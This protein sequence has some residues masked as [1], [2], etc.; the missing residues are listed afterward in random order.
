MWDL[1][2]GNFKEPTY[3]IYDHEEEILSACMHPTDPN[4]MASV[5]SEGCVIV[6]DLRVPM[7]PIAEI[8]HGTTEPA[9]AACLAFNRYS[10]DEIFVSINNTINLY[11]VDGNHVQTH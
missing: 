3:T 4:L 11:K 6:R 1:Q 8:R 2:S 5:D 7:D 10:P 9:E